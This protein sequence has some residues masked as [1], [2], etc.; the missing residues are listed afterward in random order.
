MTESRP[1]K[2]RRAVA[3]VAWL[4]GA[5]AL[6]VG[7]VYATPPLLRATG[8]WADGGSPTIAPT[9]FTSPPEP[10][11]AE[12]VVGAAPGVA[13]RQRLDPAML[14]AA[15]GALERDGIGASAFLVTDPG[16]QT[17]AG[18]DATRALIPASTM[19]MLT[20]LVVADSLKP[21]HRFA[22]RVLSPADGT[23]VL[24]GGGDP[25]LATASA[26]SGYP[27]PASLADLAKATALALKGNKQTAVTLGYDDSLFVGPDWE[28]TWEK[29]FE[30]DVTRVSALTADGGIDPA[31]K[32]RTATPAASAAAAF[33]ALLRSEG[34]DVA[35]AISPASGSGTELA[36]VESLPVHTLVQEALLRSDNT[37]TE[38]LLRHAALAAGQEASFA[39]AAA[40]LA[41]H[42]RDLG[43]WAEGAHVQDGSGVS[44]D[45]RVTATML[46]R[47]VSLVLTEERFRVLLDSFPVAGATGTLHNRFEADRTQPGRGYVRAKTGSLRDVSAL[48]GHARTAD[49]QSVVVVF[50]SNEVT[51]LAGARA[52]MDR[53][54]ALVAGCGCR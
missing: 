25:Y 42:L 33:A 14:Q 1:G 31:T 53:A 27:R 8:A 19:K 36:K 28:P 45:N 41:R 40:T 9:V 7:A 6:A 50:L 38:T 24:V 46:A 32:A 51:D 30:T 21:G 17:L 4:A 44:R 18:S 43:V 34:I 52:W 29:V 54:S 47:A 13:A 12:G 10:V 35:D 48:A 37:A 23:I 49:G 15:I 20:G 2:L 26:T 11:P 16:G 39:G 22:T 3:W 5:V